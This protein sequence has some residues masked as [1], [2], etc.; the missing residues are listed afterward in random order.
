MSKLSP[1]NLDISSR[2]PRAATPLRRNASWSQPPENRPLTPAVHIWRETLDVSAIELARLTAFLDPSE[3]ERAARY[4]FA[5]HRH[6]FIASRGLLREILAKY[7]DRPPTGLEFEYLAF[8]KPVLRNASLQFNLAHSE[9]RFILAV[10]DQPIGVDLEIRRPMSDLDALAAQVF[11]AEELLEWHG[12]RD[13]E[14]FFKLWTRKEAL[15]KGIGLGIAHHVKGVTTGFENEAK[16][17]IP[18]HLSSQ[19]WTIETRAEEDEVWSVAVPFGSPELFVIND[20]LSNVHA[21]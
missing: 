16:I 11:S 17:R 21:G 14:S 13:A 8:G 18:Q 10:A 6:R 20:A 4:K 15:L 1:P 7:L 12:L 19:P 5:I 2:P 9:Q 3:L